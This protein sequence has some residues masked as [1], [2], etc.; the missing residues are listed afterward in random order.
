MSLL[1]PRRR[2][3]HELLDDESLAP[4]HMRRSLRDLEN[5]NR[6]WHA[7]QALER[8]LLPRMLEERNGR[9]LVLDVGAGSGGVARSLS[10]SLLLAGLRAKV[11]AVD[12][13]WRHLLAGRAADGDSAAL[14]ADAFRLP[15]RDGAADWAVSTLFLHHF[16]PEENIRLLQELA[17]VTRRGFAMLDV[18]RHLIPL[19]FVA[20]AGRLTFETSVSVHDGQASV[21]QAYT[22]E[23]A[24]E[25]ARR[26]VPGANVREVF[27]FRILITG[28]DAKRKGEEETG[29]V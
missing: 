21:L 1:V 9:F 19:L 12:L 24:L 3:S 11:I 6:R 27:P 28:G 7:S 10:R 5:L 18:R 15:F 20:I 17:R 4:E 26:A 13:R 14:S 23:E 16:S 22:R 8:H 25:I 2:P 29:R